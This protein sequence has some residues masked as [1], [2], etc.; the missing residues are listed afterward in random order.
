MGTEAIELRE[1]HAM[2]DIPEDTVEAT[3]TC[4]VYIDGK[5]QTVCRK[6]SVQDVRDALRKGE[7]FYD[8]DDMFVLTEEGKKYAEQLLGNGE[9]T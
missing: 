4:V 3:L 9:N 7:E 1:A 6:L 2:I 5:L 8:D